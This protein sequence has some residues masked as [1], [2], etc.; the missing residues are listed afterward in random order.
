MLALHLAFSMEGHLEAVL[1]IFFYLRRKQKY[2]LALDPTFHY[3]DHASFK[4]HKW[5]DFY[6]NVK[7]A[8]PLYM[9]KPRGKDIYLIIYVDLDHQNEDQVWV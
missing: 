4:K 7:E 2:T 9:L 1:N 8:I 5:V 6:G 3:I